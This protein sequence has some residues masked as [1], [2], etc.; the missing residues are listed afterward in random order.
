MITKY[1]SQ[2]MNRTEL[3][4]SLRTAALKYICVQ[5]SS[6]T[7]RPSFAAAN[8]VVTLTLVTETRRDA[9]CNC[10]DLLQVSSVQVSSSCA[11]NKPFSSQRAAE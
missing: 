8:Q 11:V 10:I 7:N 2:H 5:N 3:N 4:S 1:G 9:S 6:S